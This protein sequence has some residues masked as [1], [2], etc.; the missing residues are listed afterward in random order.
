MTTI[1]R[2]DAFTFPT[3]FRMAFKHSSAARATTENVIVR[4]VL[5]DGTIGY[6]EGC[7][8]SYV[9][10]ET[11]AGSAAFYRNHLEPL[12]GAVRS[13]DDLRAWIDG[14]GELIDANPAAFCAAELAV[15]DALARADDVTVDSLLGLSPLREPFTYSAVLGDNP[16]PLFAAQAARYRWSRLTDFKI[17]LSG[18]LRRDR[19]KVSLLRRTGKLRLR[20]DAN[21]HWSRPGPC[22][23]FLR[24]LEVPLFGIEEPLRAD[25]HDGFLEIAEAI[26]SPVIL[27]ESLLRVEQLAALPGPPQ[28]WTLNCRVS[29]MGGLIRSLQAADRAAE[30]GSGLVVGAHVGETSLLT[31]AALT[32]VNANRQS[33]QAQEGAFGTYLLTSD[34]TEGPLMFGRRGRL[35]LDVLGPI[36][37]GVAVEPDR[38]RPLAGVEPEY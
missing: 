35:P 6:G 32:L 12:A 8:R 25:D 19:R 17:K 22:I 15:L 28:R 30:H 18:D 37:L 16:L 23:D 27:D 14:N 20:V 31:R 13:V 10:G 3:P 2:L 7:P 5:A 36:G 34:I 4:A 29:K 11:T 38:L 33:V 9:T 24:A 1:E 26:A 21:N